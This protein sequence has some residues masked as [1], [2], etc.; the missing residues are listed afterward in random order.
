MREH[1]AKIEQFESKA[2]FIFFKLILF[3]KGK[4]FHNA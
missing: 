3:L 1:H 2:F 4:Y